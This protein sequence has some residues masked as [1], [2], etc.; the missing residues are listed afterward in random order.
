MATGA[1]VRIPCT[2]S[3]PFQQVN[4]TIHSNAELDVLVVGGGVA[5][6]WCLN[7]L[8]EAGYNAALLESK[9]LGTGQS[10]S[11][12]GILHGGVKY[13][14][15]GLLA[16]SSS[17]IS[18]MPERW[19]QSL[20]GTLGP[21]LRAVRVRTEA[22][23][24]WRTESLR[25]IAGMAGAKLA[26]RVRP[27]RLAREDRPRILKDCPGDVALLPEKVIE[28]PSL[29][30]ALAALHPDRIALGEV[31]DGDAAQSEFATVR[32]RLADGEQLTLRTR[33]VVLTAGAGTPMLMQR[34]GLPADT[35]TMQR[36]PLHMAM[37]KGA[38]ERLAE[39]NGHCA[40][41][42][43]TRVTITSSTSDDGQRVWQ[44]GGE[45]AESGC[46]LEPDELITA[47]RSCL[48]SV[49]PGFDSSTNDLA[50]ATYRIDR[51]E[52]KNT[53]ALRPAGAYVGTS[54]AAV[55]AWPTKL[56]LAPATAREV[57]AECATSNTLPSQDLPFAASTTPP[58]ASPPWEEAR[59]T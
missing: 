44:L 21:D 30:S 38:P 24:L 36:R 47:A 25:S 19:D 46:A 37:V 1:A 39:L 43:R 18:E 7:A 56:V 22:C 2:R 48:D 57:V 34:L 20:A 26:L 4:T 8:V 31:V 10:I 45:L 59:W 3:R 28:T 29:M 52:K 27:R 13:S 16:A 9:A 33:R 12:Q 58:V 42:G 32:L 50:W 15:T 53:K 41:G 49:L 5:G 11:A 51:A 40:D 14:L 35:D 17:A 6:L 23:H 54:G 55:I